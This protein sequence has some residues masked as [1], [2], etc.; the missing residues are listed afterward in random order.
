MALLPGMVPWSTPASVSP[1]VLCVRPPKTPS[2]YF[3]P[4]L[5]LPSPQRTL[6][7]ISSPSPS[8]WHA[9]TPAPASRLPQ[10]HGLCRRR[11][12]RRRAVL[13]NRHEQGLHDSFPI[14]QRASAGLTAELSESPRRHQRLTSACSHMPMQPSERRRHA[15]RTCLLRINRSAYAMRRPAVLRASSRACWK[16]HEGLPAATPADG[17]W[18]LNEGTEKEHRG[19]VS[20]RPRNNSVYYVLCSK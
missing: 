6:C 14:R 1:G 15:L 10:P 9:G 20:I 5:G 3:H 8:S 16:R 4:A 7:A 12:P 17:R 18:S 11:K 13:Q 2:P 19:G